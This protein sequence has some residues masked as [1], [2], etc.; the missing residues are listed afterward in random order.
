MLS[1]VSVL[2]QWCWILVVLAGIIRDDSV[3]TTEGIAGSLSLLPLLSY[4][5]FGSGCAHLMVS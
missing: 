1:L 2:T 5:V 3:I 4:V